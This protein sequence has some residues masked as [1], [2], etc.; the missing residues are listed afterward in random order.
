MRGDTFYG[1]FTITVSGTP[2]LPI[3]FGAYGTGVKPIITGLTNLTTW[4]NTGVNIWEADCPSCGAEVNMLVLNNKPYA[5]GRYPNATDTNKGYLTY[6]SVTSNTTTSA[7]SITD[8]ELASMPNWTGA[9]LVVRTKKW[10]LDRRKITSHIGSVINYSTATSYSLK[11]NFGYFIQNDPKTLD[12]YGEWYYN[13]ITKKVFIYTNPSNPSSLG[14][15]VSSQDNLVTISN[16]NYIHFDNIN[17]S[18]ANKNAINTINLKGLTIKNSEFNY[19]GMRGL[20]GDLLIDLV[21]ENNILLN[22]NNNGIDIKCRDSKIKSNKLKNTGVLCGMG[23]SGNHSRTSILVYCKNTLIENNTIDSTGYAPVLFFGDSLTVKNNY[24]SNYAF[25]LD[26]CGGIYT[27]NGCSNKYSEGQWVFWGVKKKKI[28]I[29]DNIVINGIGAFEGTNSKQKISVGIYL[30]DGSNNVEISGNT[31]ANDSHGIYLH[32]S[33]ENKISN[34]T[35]FNNLTQLWMVGDVVNCFID[36]IKDNIIKKNIFFSKLPSQSVNDLS[37]NYINKINNYGVF[38]SNYYCRPF[39]ENDIMSI[40]TNTSF[41]MKNLSEWKLAYPGKD[42]NSQITPIQFPYYT[43]NNLA[44]VNKFLNGLFNTNVSGF[45]TWSPVNTQTVTWENFGI[46]DGGYAKYLPTA[47]P[48][49]TLQTLVTFQVGNIDATKK[50]ILK[51]SSKGTK[52]CDI[53][54]NLRKSQ[55][56]YFNLCPVQSAHISSSRNEHLFLFEPTITEPVSVI[57]MIIRGDD[58]TIYFDNIELYEADVAITNPDDHILF[59]YN[60]TENV[61]TVSLAHPYIDVKGNLYNSSVTLQPYTSI[62]LLWATGVDVNEY[63]S[64]ISN[65]LSVYPNPFLSSF[66]IKSNKLINEVEVYNLMG[67]LLMKQTPNL[68]QVEINNVDLPQGLYIIK[69][70]IGGTWVTSK[71]IKQ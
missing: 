9:E 53:E 2:A 62:I 15:G 40:R 51:F 27:W 38:D 34:N 18:G 14:I 55:T 30:D 3:V 20:Y 46:L 21:F 11:A 22:N 69:S 48:N 35:C 16:K 8:N 70:N 24:I 37:A 71:I 29:S 57:Q 5:M 54:V 67:Q 28:K 31:L 42:V 66:N 52:N 56:S 7:F 58:S 17:F 68:K 50:Y 13:P 1:S 60:A 4:T 41:E 25:V 64:N 33:S 44:G 32:N 61:K 6:E 43:I 26:D 12:Q 65:N 49:N 36:T 63:K 45:S 59:E 39:N 23:L 47:A 19:T 10:V